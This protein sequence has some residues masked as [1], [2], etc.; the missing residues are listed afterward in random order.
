[1]H[2]FIIYEMHVYYTNKMIYKY[3]ILTI[4]PSK[5]LKSG[6]KAIL[7]HSS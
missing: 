3:V 5:P 7:C 6:K 2:N 1:M 4:K